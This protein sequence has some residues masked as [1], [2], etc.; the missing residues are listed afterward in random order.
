MTE[1]Y[2]VDEQGSVGECGYLVHVKGV[3]DPLVLRPGDELEGRVG[4]DVTVDDPAEGEGQVLDGRGEHNSGRVCKMT[5][6]RFVGEVWDLQVTS[7]MAGACWALPMP[8]VTSQT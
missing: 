5:N 8:L 3:E 6:N 7:R 2:P 4:L 1:T